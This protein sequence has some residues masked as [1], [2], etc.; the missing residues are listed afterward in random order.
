MLICIRGYSS[1]MI[2]N[3]NVFFKIY[4]RPSCN[5]N[6]LWH[7]WRQPFLSTLCFRKSEGMVWR[8]SVCMLKCERGECI[9]WCNGCEGCV[10]CIARGHKSPADSRH[11]W[12]SSV[13]CFHCAAGEPPFI[14]PR[15]G[16]GKERNR[17]N[18]RVEEDRKER[19][20]RDDLTSCENTARCSGMHTH[21]QGYL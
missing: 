4:I 18:T 3:N 2:W 21:I 16:E 14:Q 9:R 7:A 1:I 10:Q 19:G 8:R 17:G 12:H 20:Y 6:E 5:V 15:K 11:F 13:S